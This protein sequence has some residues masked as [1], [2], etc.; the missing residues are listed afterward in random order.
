MRRKSWKVRS[1][2]VGSEGCICPCMQ[3]FPE[4]ESLLSLGVEGSIVRA[5]LVEGKYKKPKSHD[6][7]V[8]IGFVAS[9]HSTELFICPCVCHT[10]SENI[11]LRKLPSITEHSYAESCVC[12]Q[13]PKLNINRGGTCGKDEIMR[14]LSE[15]SGKD[16]RGVLYPSYHARTQ[17][18]D[19]EQQDS[20]GV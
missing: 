11:Q 3:G 9:H 12:L 2:L 8:L 14:T 18:Y 6:T 4:H 19:C 10:N 20:L 1:C 15:S 5:G 7:Q 17:E 13:T 16:P